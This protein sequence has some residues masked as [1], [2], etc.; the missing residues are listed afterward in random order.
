[1]RTNLTMQHVIA[2]FLIFF[3]TS[4]IHAQNRTIS[5]YI[6]NEEDGERL[7]GAIVYDTVTKKGSS[8]NEYGYYSLTLPAKAVVLRVSYSGMATQ[9]I[10]VPLEQ[11]EL[12]I[13]LTDQHQLNEVVIQG[14]RPVE[15]S[16]MGSID[17]DMSKVEKLPII[18][19]ERDV[20]RVLQLLPGVKSGGE[21]SSGLYVRG[22]GPDQ[23]LI[24]L[25]GV[26]VY[27]ASHLFGFFST[28]NSDAISS[29]TLHKGGFPSRYGGR[30]SS[31]IDMRMKEGNTKY[32]NIEGSVGLIASRLLIE[33]PL[34]KDKTSFVVSARRT[35]IDIL[36]QPFIYAIEKSFAGYFF[37]DFNAKIQHKINDKHHIYISG[38]FGK[39]KFY[40][41][42]K[43]EEIY[44]GENE[45]YTAKSTLQ[46]GNAIAAVR[47]NYKIGPKLFMNTTGTFSRYHFGIG[48]EEE[49]KSNDGNEETSYGYNSGILDWST[50][51]DLTYFP[52]PN[53]TIRFGA[54]DTYHTFTPGIEY[55]KQSS[56]EGSSNSE[57]G[58]PRQFSHEMSVYVEDDMKLG[59]RIKL[60]VGIHHSS[61]LT[62]GI[63]YHIPQPRV[64]GNFQLNE[65][66]SI[67]FG[68]SRMGQF[69]HLLSNSTIGLP[70]DLWV[71]ATDRTKPIYSYQY[72]LGYYLELAKDYQF[73]V[74]G[75]YKHMSNLIQYKEGVSFIS[76]GTDWQDKITT[77]QGWSYGSEFLLEKKQGKVTGWIG[78]T[79]SWTERQFDDIN[80]GKRFFYKYDR[81]HDVSLALTYDPDGPW[82]FGMVFVFS[83]GNNLTLPTHSFND[84]PDPTSSNMYTQSLYSYEQVNNFR[85]PSY[86]R[87][88]LGANKTK[89]RPAGTSTWSFS[90]YNVYNRQN[91]FMAYVGYNDKNQKALMQISLFPILPSVSWKFQFNLQKVKENK[92]NEKINNAK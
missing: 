36:T 61:F 81:R 65:K 52:H 21:A 18:L 90:I 41:N 53:H 26:P 28:F 83:T 16:E 24:L 15:S 59:Q 34:I 1:M 17:L 84:A 29:V 35:Y 85:M 88:D 76:G 32:Y 22:G 55:S 80:D 47:W 6:S 30:A 27:N 3:T 5:G 91:P 45:T 77:G 92:R 33:G 37:Q 66:S 44:G 12:S 39:D 87:L 49:Y 43:D 54:G 46:W 7:I 56:S 40:F 62:N 38:Y 11:S 51:S 48:F 14:N 60:N 67:K 23:N 25:D 69:M 8:T 72:N 70:T 31:V 19:G 75:Y 57:A 10:S 58:S 13:T 89:E 2:C 20:F 82:D 78:Y 42:Q 50:K 68:G 74:E 79:L 9:Y 4:A 63:W 73:S 71:P 86:H 64:S